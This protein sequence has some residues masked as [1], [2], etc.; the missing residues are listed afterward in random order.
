[1]LLSTLWFFITVW[2]G[3]NKILD[4]IRGVIHNYLWSWKEQL[5]RTRVSWRE[6]CLKKKYGGLGL[7]NPEAPKTSLLCKWIIKAMKSGES[8][9]QLML[10]YRLA[11]FNP[12]RGNS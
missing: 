3:S 6:C 1:M 4:K 12:Q 2:G 8:N 5:I 7:V 11:R 9:F 10:R